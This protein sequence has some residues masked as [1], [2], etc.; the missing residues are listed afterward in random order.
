MNA[1]D[2]LPG[3]PTARE[4]G[5]QNFEAGTW[6]GLFLPKGAPAPVVKTL[7]NALG[8]ALEN[9]A[10]KAKLRETGVTAGRAGSPLARVPRQV[11][12]ERSE[13]VG[14]SHQGKRRIDVAQAQITIVKAMNSFPD[15]AKT[16]AADFI[17]G[18][19]AH[20]SR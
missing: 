15:P 13:E 14:R 10:V 8:K 1:L 2:S 19:I 17:A 6:F 3:V 20:S 4:S 11:R 7:N 18:T 16:F 12:S 9:P 5:L